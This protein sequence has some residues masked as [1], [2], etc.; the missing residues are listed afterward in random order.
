M[1]GKAL[2][3]GVGSGA[4]SGRSGRGAGWRGP[5]DTGTHSSAAAGA[6]R[7]FGRAGKARGPAAVGVGDGGG[8]RHPLL[9]LRLAGGQHGGVRPGRGGPGPQRPGGSVREL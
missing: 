6:A 1:R 7:Y 5:P 8:R 9:L 3:A 4:R 2:R